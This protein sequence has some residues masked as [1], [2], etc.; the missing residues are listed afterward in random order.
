MA[1]TRIT[2]GVIKPNENYD[3]H[4]INSTGIVTATGLDISGNASIG[5]VLTYE[6][7]TSID[8]VGIITARKGI[9]SSGV[10]TA[11]AF[12]GDGSQLTGIDATALKDPAGNVKI[13]A[14]ASGAVHTGISTFQDLDVDGHTNLDNVSIA[15][16]T[17]T[18]AFQA[19]TGT[20]TGD[21][22]IASTLCHSGDTD[23][24]ITFATNTI[25][26]DTNTEERL[27]IRSDGAIG[28]NTT[29]NYSNIALSIFGADVG[30]GT[31][32]GQLI[33]K[34]TAA[35]DASPTAGII[36][37]G[38]HAAGSQAIF[39]GIR[40]FK[41]NASNG[42][43]AG[44]LAFD[45]R[46]N[47]AVAYEAARITSD[48]LV[49]IN[50]DNPGTNHNLEIL[51]NASAYATLNLKSQSL[52][53][54]SALELG[55]VDDDDY[56]S[57]YQFASGSGEGGRMRF[58]AGGVETMNLR[59]GKV[60]IGED[61]P[62]YILDVKGDSG[63]TQSAS[64]NST[65]GQV[66]IVGR[67]SGGAASAISRLKSYPEGSSNQSHFA[68]E[69]RNSSAAMVERLRID[70]DGIVSWRN[71]STPLSGTGHSYS[72]YIYRD[73]GSGYGYIDTITGG[74]NHTGVRIRAYHNGTYNNVFEHTTGDFTRFY[75]G[76]T[77]RLRIDSNGHLHAGYTSGF[78]NDHLNIL[79]S[80][81]GGVSIASN[82]AGNA[83]TG[84]ILG[85]L[86]FQ[87]YLNGQTYAN[88]EA[89]ISALVPSN[90]T[91]SSAATDMAFYTKPS[92]TG[93]GSAPTE[94]L[95]ITSNGEV[96]IISS[97]NNNDPAHLALH[98]ADVSIVTDDAIG[99]IRFAGRD[100][101][102]VSRTGAQIQATAAATWDT[103]QTNGYAASHLDFFTQN[104]SGTDTVAAGSRLRIDSDGRL[105]VANTNFSASG[106]GD[107]AI[108]GTTSGT[109]G[110]TIVSG[111]NNT[112]NIFFGDD[113]DNDIGGVVYNHNGNTINLR[114]NGL[115]RAT[116][117][118]T[119]LYVDDGTNGRVTLQPESTNVNQILSTTTGFGS[120][121]NLKYQAADHI[122][123]YGG[124]E[125]ARIKS[126]GQ[127][128][129][130]TDLTNSTYLF[131][132]RGTGHNRVE[133]LST[134]NNSAGIYLR[135]FNGGSQVSNATI[136]TGNSGNLQIYTGTTGDGERLRI[137][138]DGTYNF[139]GDGAS[140][141]SSTVASR[142]TVKV[143]NLGSIQLGA[144]GDAKRAQP[145]DKSTI[146]GLRA[147]NILDWG[148]DR[149]NS[150]YQAGDGIS[151][152]EGTWTSW[153]PN[154]T[155]T[156]NK[157]KIGQGPHGAMEWLWSGKSAY[158]DATSGQGG[159][160]TS[161]Y[162]DPN[163]T[164]M[165]IT[166]V[167]RVSSA[168]T[169][170]WYVGTGGV[171]DLGS[172]ATG[173][174]SNP[175]WTCGGIS[176]LSQNVWHVAVHYVRSYH[177]SNTDKLPNAGT[178][179][180]SDGSRIADGAN[181]NIGNGVKFNTQNTGHNLTYR[182]YLFYA[183]QNDG[184][185]LH[186]AQPHAYKCDGTEPTLMEILGRE[187]AN[188]DDSNNWDG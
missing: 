31:A 120:Y 110:I 121:C 33:L 27:R 151:N 8:S 59:G 14:Q 82:N 89:R 47:G 37:Q 70:S 66:S 169:G 96:R 56:G 60:G 2:K 153:G 112:G 88:A 117:G 152:F 116:V 118:A 176:A 43:Y 49:G 103:G 16:V 159:Y 61:S 83:T 67:N 81:G 55:A 26:F 24:K 177:S 149:G 30:E 57:I 97:G 54:G 75:T 52:S 69:T 148:L 166:Y 133:I 111:N 147:P 139:Y 13:Q 84:D 91:G 51:G 135:T 134:D 161:F 65:A 168:A 62:S 140:A 63:I 46:A 1:L 122:F 136:R 21:V 167:K 180:L 99:K 73:S 126:G 86:S 76:G 98:S 106:D 173:G 58:T 94:R 42:N 71:G 105:R 127:L 7:V 162:V 20:F 113:G 68:I 50:T 4:N 11:T 40:G 156:G 157:W 45:V 160:N 154:G 93:P 90:H 41:E 146:M 95:R 174:K 175:Y 25:K 36:F 158:S 178:Y 182:S 3:T 72:L 92:T 109:R 130:G 108:F 144:Y 185:E 15:G 181:C 186:W 187:L 78:G 17:T 164:Y 22:D 124:T 123:L 79:A 163:Y 129:I 34:D 53:H 23:T 64:S 5:G 35:Y 165:L 77:E 100:S 132:S 28:I 38:I 131:S 179:R 114:A 115:T 9:V 171:G 172:G 143:T 138:A 39:A 183:N 19:T 80:D 18:Q 150:S 125:L 48:G 137:T 107:T 155:T 104:N 12:H 141:V 74:S 128:N 44:A 10:I 6:D 119:Y 145:S 101:A 188:N 170:N 87:G 29:G 184:S 102:N 85:S 32:K 142:R